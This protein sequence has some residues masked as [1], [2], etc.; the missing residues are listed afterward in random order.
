[1]TTTAV[2]PAPSLTDALTFI[3]TSASNEDISRVIDGIK[4]RRSI[5]ATINAASVAIGEKVK[6]DGLKP[7]YLNGLTGTVESI[8]GRSATV[9]LDARSTQELRW[10]GRR[11][12]FIEA[13]ATEYPVRGLPLSTLTIVP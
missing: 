7:K 5:L 2:A 9:K 3:L 8:S 11:T 6:L 12:H 13:D 10:S 4:S 1:M